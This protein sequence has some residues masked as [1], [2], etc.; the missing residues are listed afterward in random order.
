VRVGIIQSNYLPWR[1]YFDFVGS[2]DLFV[3]HDDLQY[4]KGDWRNRNK[5]KTPT[6]LRWISVPVKYCHTTQLILDT[7][8]DYSR[9]WQRDHLNLIR[10]N[11]S[12][13]F[14][15]NDVFELLEPVFS[16]KDRTISELNIRLIRTICRYLDISTPTKQS[17]EFNLK[18]RRTERLI[19]LLTKVGAHTYVSGPNA[20]S[21]LDERQFRDVGIGLEY[22]RYAYPEYPQLWGPFEGGV[23][24]IDLIANCG[25]RSKD[26]LRSE[27]P[28]D[29][30]VRAPTSS[31]P[32][33]IP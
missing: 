21:Y 4:T 31:H 17:S 24:I 5:I 29:V 14:Y 19:E 32:L 18:T 11:Y 25:P 23:S 22:K 9:S 33:S 15:S 26:F 6:G 2:V 16:H 7:A 10:A 27:I 1:G 28:D 12:R 13:A 3:F 30:I 8:I 20:K